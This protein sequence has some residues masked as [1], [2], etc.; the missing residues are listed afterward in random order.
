MP[1][2]SL[3]QPW[4][5]LLVTDAPCSEPP[6][7]F[8]M[9]PLCRC[10]TKIK[11]FETRSWPCPPKYIGQ[12]IAIHAAKRR[13]KKQN[14]GD[15]FVWW[16]VIDDGDPGE[17]MMAPKDSTNPAAR[18]PLPLGAVVGS[19]IITASLPIED[20]S[21]PDPQTLDYGQVIYRHTPDG[22]EDFLL[23]TDRFVHPP[24]DE[25]IEDQAPYG[26]YSTT[27]KQRYAWIIEQA[28]A[29]TERCPYH[30]EQGIAF[31]P[32]GTDHNPQCPGGGPEC[33]RLC[34]VPVCV[35]C[36]LEVGPGAI[37]R[38]DPIPAVGH[39]GIWQWTP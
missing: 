22:P 29:T 4:A 28:A 38:C 17:A 39:Q 10:Q 27:G 35:C 26:D 8:G 15:Y 34:P 16:D 24:I 2:I 23:R 14:I 37:G 19:G 5:S 33:D 1:A 9:E 3:W 6:G 18:I 31:G 21:D 32:W 25:H 7:Y 36:H 13:P 11:R 12:R 30:D 20:L